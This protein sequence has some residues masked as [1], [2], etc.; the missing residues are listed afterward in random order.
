MKEKYKDRVKLFIC[1]TFILAL[2]YVGI[3]VSQVEC[4]LVSPKK[5]VVT[6]L[7]ACAYMGIAVYT[8]KRLDT[9]EKLY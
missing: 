8:Y 2:T 4:E 3:R 7:I 9:D 1:I 6:G 5:A